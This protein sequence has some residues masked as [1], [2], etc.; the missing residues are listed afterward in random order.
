MLTLAQHYTS[1]PVDAL[2]A[3]EPEE[4][5]VDVVFQLV[6]HVTWGDL[7]PPFMRVQRGYVPGNKSITI[8][9]N[10]SPSNG[11]PVGSIRVNIVWICTN[12]KHD[13]IIHFVTRGDLWPAFVGV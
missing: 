13:I 1:P 10:T 11:M 3:Q 7:G 8:L 4:A 5:G 9:I 6:L 12:N 2:W